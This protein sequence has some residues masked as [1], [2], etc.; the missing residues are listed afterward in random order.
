MKTNKTKHK[1][2]K[3]SENLLYR[4]NAGGCFIYG[5]QIFIQRT[6]PYTESAH[7]NYS[8]ANDTEIVVLQSF[9][10]KAIRGEWHDKQK[11]RFWFCGMFNVV[12]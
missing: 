9:H 1:Q 10:N 6:A 8:H 4:S 11:W 2:R 7:R 12:D 3:Q 5:L